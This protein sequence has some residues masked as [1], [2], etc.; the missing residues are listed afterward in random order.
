MRLE[1]DPQADNSLLGQCYRV[2]GPISQAELLKAYDEAPA[3]H[4][5]LFTL[6]DLGQ[7]LYT[8]MHA[9]HYHDLDSGDWLLAAGI[10]PSWLQ[11]GYP[12]EDLS[13]EQ[14]LHIRRLGFLRLLPQTSFD[15]IFDKDLRLNEDSLSELQAANNDLVSQLDSEC[16]L[17]RIAAQRAYESLY[18]FANGYFSCDLSPMENFRLAEH[19]EDNYGYRLFGL[20]ASLI[21][22]R[23]TRALDAQQASMLLDLLVRLYAG[24]ENISQV[25]ALFRDSLERELLVLRYTE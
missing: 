16:Y 6:E 12:R 21:A 24:E 11:D 25:R 3:G 2:N 4:Q 22:F 10:D 15:S 8:S 14:R 23:R 20:G 9:S 18:G 7:A 5:H 17:L 19:L 1:L 13:L